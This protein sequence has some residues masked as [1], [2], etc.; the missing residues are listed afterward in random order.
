MAK[1]ILI[2]CPTILSCHY[3]KVKPD[4]SETISIISAIEDLISK[5]VNAAS[6]IIGGLKYLISEIVDNVHEHSDS[7]RGYIFSQAY[8]IKGYLDICIADNGISLL[9]SYLKAS[10]TGIITHLDAMK[11][12]NRGESTKNLPD[13]EN[14]GYGIDTSKKM[15]TQ[16]LNGNFLM[17]SGNVLYLKS[18]RRENYLEL[19][20]WLEWKGTIVAMRL[21]SV[22]EN[23]YYA[24]FVE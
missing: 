17:L 10:K 18:G 2:I 23:F 6:N 3:G 9:G 8:P 4:S 22:K 11:A 24:N 12:A 7:K 1:N 21:P 5:Q 13:A 19:P 16:G 20:K 14:R 15:V